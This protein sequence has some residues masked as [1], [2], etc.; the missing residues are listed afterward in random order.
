[1]ERMSHTAYYFM[2][3]ELLRYDTQERR[4]LF[5]YMIK[6]VATLIQD[7]Q[8]RFNFHHRDLHCKNIMY[9]KISEDNYVWYMIDFDMSVMVSNGLVINGKKTKIYPEFPYAEYT[10]H[11]HDLRT[12]LSSMINIPSDLSQ[13]KN[14]LY[15][16][17]PQQCYGRSL[18]IQSPQT[19]PIEIIKKLRDI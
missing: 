11:G 18:F 14:E 19:E 13:I 15:H 4:R 10:N 7:C 8:K 6:S 3:V 16:M 9:N 12:F 1:M 5:I 17:K 2:N